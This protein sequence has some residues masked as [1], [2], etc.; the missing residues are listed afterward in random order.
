MRPTCRMFIWECSGL[1][2]V[3]RRGTKRVAGGQQEA[4]SWDADPTG[5]SATWREFWSS[6]SPS[7]AS[8]V[9]RLSYTASIR[10]TW[11]HHGSGV[12]CVT[13]LQ[14]RPSAKC[15]PRGWAEKSPVKEG[16]RLHIPVATTAP[17]FS[18]LRSLISGSLSG[19]QCSERSA[20]TGGSLYKNLWGLQFPSSVHHEDRRAPWGGR[21]KGGETA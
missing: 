20:T 19:G 13:S 8:W 18:F 21:R 4:L 14:L 2:P 3:G 1:Y 17:H 7:T 16:F 9:G 12:T 11:N 6:N 5:T 15:A 10:V